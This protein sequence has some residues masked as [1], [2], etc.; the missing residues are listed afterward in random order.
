VQIFKDHHTP[1]KS[2]ILRHK[3]SS[4]KFRESRSASKIEK[5]DEIDIKLKQLERLYDM[6][7]DIDEE[8]E[9]EQR[10]EKLENT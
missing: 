2:P 8:V 1:P 10:I 5:E 9:I 4:K 7:E 6:F 3:F